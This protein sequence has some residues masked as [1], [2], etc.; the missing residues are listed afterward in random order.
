MF[1]GT[2]TPLRSVCLLNVV[3]VVWYLLGFFSGK[4]PLPFLFDL[5][6]II[7]FT[8]VPDYV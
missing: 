4:Y 2:H 1:N 5:K 6:I 7:N 3:F 8:G